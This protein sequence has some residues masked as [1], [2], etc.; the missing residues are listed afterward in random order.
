MKY[1]EFRDSIQEE[2]IKNPD[3]LTWVE[4]R[5]RLELPYERPCPT[6]VQ[7]LEKEIGLIRSKGS[8]RALVWKIP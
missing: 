3:G 7:R 1:I 6:W 4:L 2:L 8:G 5:N